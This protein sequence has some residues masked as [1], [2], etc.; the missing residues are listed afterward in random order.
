M[1]TWK[2]R[3][4][5]LQTE[6][7]GKREREKQDFPA[8]CLFD[9]AVGRRAGDWGGEGNKSSS[10][11]DLTFEK[12]S[13]PK[14]LK[15]GS[16]VLYYSRLEFTGRVCCNRARK[17][18]SASGEWKLSEGSLGRIFEREKRLGCAESR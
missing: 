2:I 14:L 4:I 17:G 5:S 3:R 8:K 16:L 6:N 1:A 12:Q 18:V 7:G 10:R 13:Q 11:R 15:R 9:K